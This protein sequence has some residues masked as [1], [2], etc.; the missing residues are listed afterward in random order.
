M[1]YISNTEKQKKEML[2]VLGLSTVDSLFASIPASIRLKKPLNIKGSLSEPE[3]IRELEQI[4]S[5]NNSIDKINSFLGAGCYEH[6]VPSAVRYIT[7][8]TEFYTAY[9]PYQPEASQGTLQA[10][11]EYQTYICLL[12]GMDITCAS[13][14]DGA[15]SCAEAVL[16]AHRVNGRNKIFIASNLHPEYKRVIYTYSCGFDL[17]IKEIPCNAE[18]LL[19]LDFISRNLDE[20][21]SSILIQNPNFF[22]GLE[23]VEKITQIAHQKGALVINSVY[24]MS[25]GILKTPGEM[26]VD[27]VV[28]DGQ[29]LGNGMNFGGPSFGFLACKKEFARKMPG[30][31]VGR[32]VDKDNKEGFVLT[33]QAREQHIRREKATSNICSNQSLNALAACV[34]FASVGPI[35]FKKISQACCDNAH[36]LYEKLS[37]IKDLVFPLRGIFFNE[38]LIKLPMDA[39]ELLAELEKHKIIGGLNVTKFFPE[40]N[41]AILVSCTEL[42]TQAQI[43]DYSDKM[44]KIFRKEKI[45]T[46]I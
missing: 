5:K 39:K 24:P 15:S 20:H 40:I 45:N 25:L 27:I 34:Y 12:T 28:G 42:K 11:Y 6:F 16:M 31:I 41:H 22:G 35:G 46:K 8:R 44:S 4:A 33:L 18:F 19:N 21:T 13:L 17:D 38:F 23:E 26:D 43:E 30:R 3:L 2:A 32:T 14:Y 9:T 10:I 1:A 7:S 29:S 37:S 36:Y